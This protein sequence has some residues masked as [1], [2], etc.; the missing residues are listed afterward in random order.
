MSQKKNATRQVQ[1]I[2]NREELTK[3]A[4]Y[5]RWKERGEQHGEDLNDWYEAEKS[6]GDCPA[7]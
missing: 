5:Y 3:L 6:L 4:A 1:Q 2:E 7:S